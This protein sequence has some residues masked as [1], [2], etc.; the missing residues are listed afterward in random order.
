MGH[1]PLA[2]RVFTGSVSTNYSR[3]PLVRGKTSYK[4]NRVGPSI[5][6][7]VQKRVDFQGIF[8]RQMMV[9]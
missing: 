8:L 6:Y 2:G 4:G 7:I 9:S 1:A 3:Y 5:F